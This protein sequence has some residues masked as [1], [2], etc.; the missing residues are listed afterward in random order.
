MGCLGNFLHL[1]S[2]PS[3]AFSFPGYDDKEKRAKYETYWLL[4]PHVTIAQRLLDRIIHMAPIQLQ[5]IM[6]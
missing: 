5:G 6:W 2:T 1:G 4:I 3:G